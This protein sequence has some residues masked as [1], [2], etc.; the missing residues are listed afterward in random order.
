MI[1]V[2]GGDIYR[3]RVKLDFSVNINPLGMPEESVRAAKE[4]LEGCGVYP[5]YMG[6]ALCDALAEKEGT[7]RGQVILGNGAAELIYAVCAAV[8]NEREERLEKGG[9]SP[10]RVLTAAP[11][12]Q[13]YE[14]AAEAAG[15]E[16]LFY[17]QKEEEGFLL[18]EGILELL[19]RQR[20]QI[21]FLCNPGNPTG[22]LIPQ[23]LLERIAAL[24]ERT[25]T[26]LCVDE[27]FLPFLEEEG[28]LTL[29]H[30]LEEFPHLIV[31]RAFTKVYA[32]PGLRLGYALT[33]DTLF[34]E[35]MKRSMQPWNTSIPAQAAGLAALS[36]K[37]YLERTRSLIREEKAWLKEALSGGLAEKVYGSTA[38]YLFFRARPDL[39]ERLLEEGILIRSCEGFR[40]LGPGFFRIGIRTHEENEEL[41]R[42]WQKRL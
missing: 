31:L 7:E 39:K 17:T 30:R 23:P 6:E 27:C 19:D 34:L 29:K 28:R 20:P 3:N 16:T 8:R 18:T 5:D 32:M 14:A 38:D 21:L 36:A 24:C 12:F 42:I 37:G 35:R 9:W 10:I 4:A 33:A 15:G 40:G 11:S 41:I 26:R 1:Y 22:V 2:H 25:G 13:E